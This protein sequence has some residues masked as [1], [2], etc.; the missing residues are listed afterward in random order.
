MASGI[1][2]NI[3]WPRHL[4]SFSKKLTGE[5]YASK[6]ATQLDQ[7]LFGPKLDK[8]I[9]APPLTPYTTQVERLQASFILHPCPATCMQDDF[10]RGQLLHTTLM[11]SACGIMASAALTRRRS[12][13]IASGI[14]A[15]FFHSSSPPTGSGTPVALSLDRSLLPLAYPPPVSISNPSPPTTSSI[16]C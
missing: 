3:H 12:L 9:P 1:H 15:F 7:A 4:S 10:H 6:E 16:P 8:N 14:Y 11:S 5:L 13:P 2:G